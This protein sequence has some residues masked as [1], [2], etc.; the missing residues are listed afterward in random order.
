MSAPMSLTISMRELSSLSRA[1]MRTRSSV[2]SSPK[3]SLYQ[4]MRSLK[5]SV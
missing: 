4:G 3:F 2:K 5:Y 1:M